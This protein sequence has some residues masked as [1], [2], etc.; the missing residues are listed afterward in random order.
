MVF[1]AIEAL[2]ESGPGM[3]IDPLDGSPLLAIAR[4]S[5]WNQ[6]VSVTRPDGRKAARSEVSAVIGFTARTAF[7]DPLQSAGQRAEAL[8]AEAERLNALS[9]KEVLLEYAGFSQVVQVENFRAVPSAGWE[10]IDLE[11]QARYVTL[12]GD[13]AEV[14][15]TSEVTEDPATGEIRTV[16]AG[17][18]KA[19]DKTTAD[20]KVEAILTAWRTA[21]RRVTRI[22]KQ[23]AWLD[24]EDVDLP[25]WTGLEFTLELTESGEEPR[26]TLK[27]DTRDGDDGRK[28]TY[29][30][31]AYAPTLTALLQTIESISGGKHAITLRQETSIDLATDDVG[32]EKLMGGSFTHEYAVG[33]AVIMGSATRAVNNSR[34]ADWQTS[35]SGSIS[36]TT[37]NDARAISRNLIPAGVILRTDEET[38]GMALYGGAQQL[39]T[40]NFSYAWGRTHTSTA[41][42]YEDNSSPDYTRMIL[43]REISG[44]CHALTKAGAESAVQALMDGLVGVTAMPTKKSLGHSHE[45]EITTSPAATLDRWVVLRFG[46]SYELPITGTVG[47]DIIEASFALQRIGMINHKPMTEIPLQKPVTQVEMGYNIGRLVASGTVRARQQATART[48]GQ[49]KRAIAS[50]VGIY[51]GAEDPPDERMGVAYVPFD[52]SNV[53]TYEFSFQ[54]GFRYADGLDGVWPSSG[55]TVW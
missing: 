16:V 1:S 13:E 38:E 51:A 24:G 6:N 12:P 34:L 31:T 4:P 11:A 2:A 48:W 44:V 21:A 45:R 15:F 47:H 25:E 42:E 27:I 49:A 36:A 28:I 20:A 54:Y 39:M 52:G 50:N 29:S 43:Q 7:A 41:M 55:L 37:L 26:Y 3:V 46:Y 10:W 35:V 9:G 32:T 33:A 18:I 17:S 5:G 53:T 8:L 22:R 14:S 30:G 23:D 19:A 40:L